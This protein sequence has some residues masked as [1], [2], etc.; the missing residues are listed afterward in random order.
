MATLDSELKTIELGDV[1][2]F[3]KVNSNVTL[4]S[5]FEKIVF[6]DTP[7]SCDTKSV[8]VKDH[9]IGV[10]AT[11]GNIAINL[12]KLND[13]SVSGGGR[14]LRFIRMDDTANTVTIQTDSGATTRD[15]L[16]GATAN[17]VVMPTASTGDTIGSTLAI[18]SAGETDG[19]FGKV[20]DN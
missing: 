5:H 12:P 17:T 18:Y 3:S 4:Q 13:N 14:V 9:I 1:T 2:W 10:D 11:G 16:N 8:T 6:G 20:Y 7:Y 19:W 15:K